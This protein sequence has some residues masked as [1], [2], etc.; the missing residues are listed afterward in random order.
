MYQF[1]KSLLTIFTI[2]PQV[3]LFFTKH[4]ENILHS[5]QTLALQVL[6][7]ELALNYT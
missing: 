1:W 6:V 4:A 7:I 2:D 3:S 5:M